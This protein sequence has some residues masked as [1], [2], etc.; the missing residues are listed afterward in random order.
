MAETALVPA[1]VVTVTE[2]LCAPVGTAAVRNVDEM[3]VTEGLVRPLIETVEVGVNPE[4]EMRITPL[5]TGLTRSTTGA[6]FVER[7]WYAGSRP[8]GAR[9]LAG[10]LP[11]AGFCSI[12]TFPLPKAHWLR[13]P[14]LSQP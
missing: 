9:T 4:P 14:R 8:A 5:V 6:S 1:A 7:Y 10:T 12:D 3:K 11:A 13:S 2:P